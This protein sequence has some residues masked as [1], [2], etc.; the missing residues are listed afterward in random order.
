MVTSKGD[1]MQ[2]FIPIG[3]PAVGKTTLAKVFAKE[4]GEDGVVSR[5]HYR[6]VLTGDRQ[7]HTEEIQVTSIC[8]RILY[9][10]IKHNQDVFLDG[11]NVE[12]KY[13]EE[14]FNRHLFGEKSTAEKHDIDVKVYIIEPEAERL[15]NCREWNASREDKSEIVPDYV[16]DKMMY[17]YNNFPWLNFS[18]YPV[19]LLSFTY[20]NN[21]IERS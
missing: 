12:W 18:D 21:Y 1:I 4:Y 9:T 10:R 14:M 11:C 6:K 3:P 2:L 19:H 15:D 7:N 20:V 8:D 13:I 5:D 17:R 16:M